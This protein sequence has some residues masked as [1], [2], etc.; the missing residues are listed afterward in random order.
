MTFANTIVMGNEANKIRGKN[1]TNTQRW[2][3]SDVGGGFIT[4]AN[5]G[6][7]MLLS[8]AASEFFNFA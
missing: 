4:A 2:Y 7:G 5:N 3:F 8:G 6:T 1:D